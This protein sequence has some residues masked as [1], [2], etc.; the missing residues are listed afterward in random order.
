[1]VVCGVDLLLGLVVGEGAVLDVSGSALLVGLIRAEQ[2]VNR[3]SHR[4]VGQKLLCVHPADVCECET[5]HK[6]PHHNQTTT[7]LTQRDPWLVHS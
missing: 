7:K 4:Q 3:L 6:S 2:I 1:M 5:S